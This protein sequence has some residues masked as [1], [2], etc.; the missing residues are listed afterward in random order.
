[1][2]NVKNSASGTRNAFDSFNYETDYFL[3]PFKNSANDIAV[4]IK[5]NSVYVY[6]K[7]FT[8]SWQTAIIFPGCIKDR[9]MILR[10]CW[11]NFGANAHTSGTSYNCAK[12]ST[13]SSGNVLDDSSI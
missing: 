11:L 10:A 6:Y 4:L 3:N 9:K 2:T 1:M 5:W 12:W 7:Q 8:K 13:D